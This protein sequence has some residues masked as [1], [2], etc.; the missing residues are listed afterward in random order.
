MVADLAQALCLW[1]Y[2]TAYSVL[3]RENVHGL[4]SLERIPFAN[5]QPKTFFGQLWM[6]QE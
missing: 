6:A 5:F 3:A 4:R 2:W 1:L